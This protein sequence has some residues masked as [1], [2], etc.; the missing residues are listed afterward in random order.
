MSRIITHG[1]QQDDPRPMT[2]WQRDRSEPALEPLAEF[3]T[4]LRTAC[5]AIMGVTVFAAL[6]GALI[7]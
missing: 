2:S 1:I 3:A 7:S 4:P 5:F 6:F